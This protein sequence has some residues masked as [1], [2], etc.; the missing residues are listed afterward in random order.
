M[1]EHTMTSPYVTGASVFQ[2][3]SHRTTPSWHPQR[4]TKYSHFTYI[5][6]AQPMPGHN[7]QVHLAP[8]PPFTHPTLTPSNSHHLSH[9]S[10]SMI[11]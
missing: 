7:P 3:H 11:K 2:G 6:L 8:Y 9:S 4:I 10:Q 1:V 5:G